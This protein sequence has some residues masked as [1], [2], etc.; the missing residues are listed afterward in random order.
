[1]KFFFRRIFLI[2]FMPE[3]ASLVAE[4]RG[5]LEAYREH[6]GF[7]PTVELLERVDGYLGDPKKY[8]KKA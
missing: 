1:M 6:Y 3:L 5:A 8:E 4:M 2:I 7:K